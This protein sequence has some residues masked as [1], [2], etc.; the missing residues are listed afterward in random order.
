LGVCGSTVYQL[1]E[2]GE[3]R[4]VGCRMRSACRSRRWRRTFDG[5]PGSS[6]SLQWRGAL[7]TGPRPS[8]PEDQVFR[9]LRRCLLRRTPGTSARVGTADSLAIITSES[10]LIRAMTTSL[11]HSIRILSS[12]NLARR[13]PAARTAPEGSKRRHATQAMAMGT[14]PSRIAVMSPARDPVCVARSVALSAA[15]VDP[16]RSL[17]SCYLFS[18]I[19]MSN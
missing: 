8:D 18:V 6:E 13:S 19:P 7:V 1:C 10:P 5:R 15:F 17:E 3:L 16:R 4:L 2:R 9:F 12:L 14:I 11:S